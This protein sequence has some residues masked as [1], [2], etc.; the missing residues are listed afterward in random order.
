MGNHWETN[1]VL[2]LGANAV[3]FI[4]NASHLVAFGN[5]I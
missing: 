5:H 4:W 2:L 1:M 3:M